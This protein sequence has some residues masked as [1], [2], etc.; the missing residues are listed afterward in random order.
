[1]DDDHI[2]PSWDHLLHLL[3]EMERDR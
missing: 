2:G 3:P 1:M